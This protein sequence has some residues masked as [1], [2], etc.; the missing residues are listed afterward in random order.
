MDAIPG[1]AATLEKPAYRAEGVFTLL[2]A[3]LTE[4]QGRVSYTDYIDAES[5]HY[6]PAFAAEAT[7]LVDTTVPRLHDLAKYLLTYDAE[8][9]IAGALGYAVEKGTVKSVLTL[10]E[11]LMEYDDEHRLLDFFSR[12]LHGGVV[13]TVNDMLD[14]VH[15][16]G[17][18]EKTIPIFALFCEKD[19][20]PE[21]LDVIY[22][23]LPLIKLGNTQ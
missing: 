2:G 20:W 14:V 8:G 15:E 6:R 23:V 4:A 7:Q 9:V 22:E 21:L 5:A 1:I 3:A 19:V 17:L 13:T 11:H 16:R 12:L 10:F 18:T